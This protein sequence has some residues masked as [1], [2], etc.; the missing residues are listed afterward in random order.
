M[1]GSCM[2]ILA[3]ASLLVATVCLLAACAQGESKAAGMKTS[4]VERGKYI[5]EGLGMC[6]DCH[7]PRNE[8][9]EFIQSRL[10]MGSEL[11]FKP[12]VP[13][14][15]WAAAAPGIAGLPTYT[16]AQAVK[17]LESGETP[18]GV[19]LRPPMPPYRMNHDDAVAVV[20]YLR[21]LARQTP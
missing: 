1:K 9:G 17:I 18:T 2:K 21:S 4:S 10:L 15:A 20:A 16:D 8:K 13:M 12:A 14:P 19:P 7:T 11:D 6:S 3:R 5:V